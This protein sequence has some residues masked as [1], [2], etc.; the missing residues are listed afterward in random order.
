MYKNWSKSLVER[1][2][3]LRMIFKCW[4]LLRRFRQ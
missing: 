1:K 2:K 3:G 4:L